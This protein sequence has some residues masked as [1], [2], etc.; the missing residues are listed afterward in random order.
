MTHRLA[1][2]RPV[3]CWV[4]AG[5]MLLLSFAKLVSIGEVRTFVPDPIYVSVAVFEMALGVLLVRLRYRQLALYV[6]MLMAVIGV[7]ASWSIASPCGCLGG[8]ARAKGYVYLAACLQGMVAAVAAM[9]E[10]SG[11]VSNE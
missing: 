10:P 1:V 6:C 7:V 8:L 11:H 4:L 5:W 9:G 2:V 3:L